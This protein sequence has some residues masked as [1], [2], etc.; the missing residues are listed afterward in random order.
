VRVEPNPVAASDTAT[1][2]CIIE[3]SLDKRFRFEWGFQG[4]IGD[5]ITDENFIHWK[6]PD[7][8]GTFN[9]TV[10]VFNGSQDS[11][12]PGRSFSIEVVSN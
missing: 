1:F 9:H 11:V 3:D 8:S 4:V 2:I 10:E 5:T 12:A 6:A 7:T